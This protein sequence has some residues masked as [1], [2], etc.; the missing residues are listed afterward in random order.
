MFKKPCV[1]KSVNSLNKLKLYVRGT[2]KF[3]KSTLFRDMVLEEY[4]GNPE[5]GL[6]VGVGAEYGYAL[7]DNLNVSHIESWDDAIE[8]KKYLIA[9]KVRGDH[10]IELVAF[11]TLDELIPL[12]EQYVCKLSEKQTG[13]SCNTINGALGGLN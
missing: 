5:K 7:L 8:L 6:L 12:C 1:N 4:D 10:E 11:D 9:G 3:G 13:K 2:S